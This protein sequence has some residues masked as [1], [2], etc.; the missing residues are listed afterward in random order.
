MK[1][2]ILGFILLAGMAMLSCQRK[3][4]EP[5]ADTTAADTAAYTIESLSRQIMQDSSNAGLFRDR[6]MLYL[7]QQNPNRA[8]RDMNAAITLNPGNPRFM[9]DLADIF[10]SMGLIENTMESLNKALSL[11]PANM[12][13]LLKLAEINLILQQ[14][15][16]AVEYSD[17]AIVLERS[18][19]LPY[20]IKAY[21]F[22]ETGDTLRAIK[23]YLEAITVDQ[24]YYDAYIQ[25]GLIYSKTKNRLAI[26][27]LNNA[28]NIRPESIEA[29]YALALVYQEQEQ[30]DN[31]IQTYNRLLLINPEHIHAIYNLGYVHLV[32]LN[33]Y[34]QAITYF[35]KVLELNPEYYDA[36]Y[37][38][39]YCY[40]LLGDPST[41]WD[42]YKQVLEIAVNHE[43]AINGLNRLEGR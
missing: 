21:T 5:A 34:E 31:A 35:D 4:S 19:P 41:A 39:A 38:K 22:A 8:L 43:K 14:Y 16:A 20:F 15:V 26:D 33:D 37:N 3:S 6:A 36:L 1:N 25:L 27:Y 2:I 18:N 28:L 23:T 10:L 9:L 30:A 24:E 11:D 32:L 17:K 7:A 13:T 40:E 42:L 29:L 12:E